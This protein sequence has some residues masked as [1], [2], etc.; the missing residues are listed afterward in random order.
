M[1]SPSHPLQ[2][3]KA[4]LLSQGFKLSFNKPDGAKRGSSPGVCPASTPSGYNSAK[5]Y[6]ET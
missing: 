6:M 5:A 1:Q 4:E 3:I 2:L